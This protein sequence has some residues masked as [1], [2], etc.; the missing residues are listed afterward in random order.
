MDLSIQFQKKSDRIVLDVYFDK[1]DMGVVFSSAYELMAEMNPDIK[2]KVK[3]LKEYP[4]KAKNFS[5]FRNN[6]PYIKEFSKVGIEFPNMARGKQILEV[7]KTPEL[8]YCTVDD[9]VGFKKFYNEY[10]QLKKVYDK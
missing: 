9:L 10:L 8:N 5:F 1:A 3:I 2:N 6:Y 4:I 7:F